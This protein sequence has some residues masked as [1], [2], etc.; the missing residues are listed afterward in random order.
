M[1][2]SR[3]YMLLPRHADAFATP[4]QIHA[5]GVTLHVTYCRVTLKTALRYF[6]IAMP[7]LRR[8]R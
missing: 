5:A 3:H 1:R 8:V 6:A 7:P 4:L 2:F